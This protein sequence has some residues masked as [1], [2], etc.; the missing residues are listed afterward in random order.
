MR[1]R[2]YFRICQYARTFDRKK[3]KFII[4]VGYK[5][6]PPKP[7]S[8]VVG[9]AEGFGLGLDQWEKFVIHDNVELKIAPTDIVYITG[10]SGEGWNAENSQATSAKR[11]PKGCGD[12]SAAWIQHSSSRQRKYVLN[13]LQ[14]LSDENLEKIREAFIKHNHTRFMKYF[15]CHIPFGKKKANTEQVRKASLE[16]LAPI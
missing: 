12:P 7:T 13:K 9:V 1:R 4:S 2:E 8:R 5:T 16:K 3:G 15:F 6:A 14:N 10:D 11:S